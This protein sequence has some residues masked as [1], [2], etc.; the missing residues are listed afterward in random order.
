M[1]GLLGIVVVVA[2]DPSPSTADATEQYVAVSLGGSFG[3]GCAV[4]DTGAMRCWGDSWD[5]GLANGTGGGTFFDHAPALAPVSS[6]VTV[7]AIQVGGN[8]TL[9]GQ[10]VRCWG[11]AGVIEDG[12]GSLFSDPPWGTSVPKDYQHGPST[13]VS[14]GCALR[15]DQTVRC[16]GWNSYGQLGNGSASWPRSGYSFPPPS[17]STAVSVSG[18]SGVIDLSQTVGGYCALTNDGDGT[19]SVWCWGQGSE[20]QLGDGR[21]GNESVPCGSSTCTDLYHATSPVRVAGLD[22][23]VSVHG[24]CAIRSNGRVSCWGRNDGGRFDPTLNGV[25]NTAPTFAPI[26]I[27]AFANAVDVAV[28]RRSACA[29]LADGTVRCQGAG[30]IGDGATD[31]NAQRS[32]VLQTFGNETADEGVEIAAVGLFGHCVRTRSGTIACWGMSARNSGTGQSGFDDVATP[33]YVIGFGGELPEDELAVKVDI[34]PREIELA[35]D[36]SGDPMPDDSVVATVTVENTS[37]DDVPNVALDATL[38]TTL[39]QGTTKAIEQVGEPIPGPDDITDQVELGTIPAGE[40]RTVAYTFRVSEAGVYGVEALVRWADPTTSATETG[41]DEHTI[42]VDVDD[43]FD[44]V[45][46]GAL[47]T[48][49]SVIE[50]TAT[51][52]NDSSSD[53]VGLD[54]RDGLVDE[55]LSPI[56]DENGDEVDT[57][58]LAS[59]RDRFP[60]CRQPSGWVSRW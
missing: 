49:P 2:A 46:E 25:S 41:F 53:F 47:T 59:W 44:V 32:V 56:V 60:H 26:D 33:T 58:P 6:V 18:L 3:G 22:D 13:K 28:Q 7:G 24:E 45:L 14:G 1:V 34:E 38:A 11:A 16:Y 42:T 35:L 40:S 29:V 5:G 12:D 20:G 43:G 39:E 48:S 4:T 57:D 27:P 55:V 37:A 30:A 36:G 52:R 8:C 21:S 10:N 50:L 54:W 19:T 17:A 9:V 23:V 51:I 31:R 15:V